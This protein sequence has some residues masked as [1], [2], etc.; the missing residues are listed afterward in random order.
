MDLL[1]KAP[2]APGEYKFSL[3]DTTIDVLGHL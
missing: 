1:V 3:L 2:A